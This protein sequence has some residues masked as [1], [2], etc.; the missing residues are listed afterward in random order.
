MVTQSFNFVQSLTEKFSHLRTDGSEVFV[1]S[2]V[3][4]LAGSQHINR[5]S[6]LRY[7]NKN[8]NLSETSVRNTNFIHRYNK[9]RLIPRTLYA[10]RFIP[11]F[12]QISKGKSKVVPVLN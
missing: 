12:I 4:E 11:S 9:S 1:P 8:R 5:G 7:E 6:A 2:S 3:L 10:L